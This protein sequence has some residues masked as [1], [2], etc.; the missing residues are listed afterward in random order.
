MVSM[1]IDTKQGILDAVADMTNRLTELLST[2]G[3]SDQVRKQTEQALKAQE[4]HKKNIERLLN[5]ATRRAK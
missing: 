3:I 5:G 4:R 1:P 2:P